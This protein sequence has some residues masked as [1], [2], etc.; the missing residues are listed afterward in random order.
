MFVSYQ[1]RLVFALHMRTFFWPKRFFF[2]V[3]LQQLTCV[4]PYYDRGASVISSAHVLGFHC[5]W[6]NRSYGR[7]TDLTQI[8]WCLRKDTFST[9][10]PQRILIGVRRGKYYSSTL[11]SIDVDLWDD[12]FRIHVT[13]TNVKSQFTRNI[14]GTQ[15]EGI[16]CSYQKIQLSPITFEL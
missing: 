14:R 8:E 3:S 15:I 5:N 11:R 13:S 16:P 9:L 6:D 7:W 12:V 4:E 1:S 10:D 2:H